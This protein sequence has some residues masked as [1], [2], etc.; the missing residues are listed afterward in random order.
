MALCRDWN[1]GHGRRRRCRLA[2][3][4]VVVVLVVLVV[5]I[6]IVVIRIG[7]VVRLLLVG[8]DGD[9]LDDLADLHDLLAEGEEEVRAVMVGKVAGT[10]LGLK[11]HRC[12]AGAPRAR[13]RG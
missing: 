4:L 6:V 11:A 1:R 5:L 8:L 13:A 3:L 10:S 9:G 2:F 12:A 7:L